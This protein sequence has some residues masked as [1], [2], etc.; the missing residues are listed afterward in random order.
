MPSLLRIVVA[1]YRFIGDTLLSIPFLK[2]LREKNPDAV[3]DLLVGAD[4][5]P[6]MEDCPYINQAIVFEPRE[7][8]FFQ[9]V[10]KIREGRYEAAYLLKRSFSSALMMFLAQVPQRIGF[11]T[12]HRGFLLTRKMPYREFDQHEAQCFLD[13]LD[14][15]SSPSD[16]RLESWIPQ[17][18]AEKALSLL[19]AGS[20]P[21]IVL[22][23][24]STN[25]AKR[26]PLAHFQALAETL[27]S[28]FQARLYLLGSP[29]EA[30]FYDMLTEGLSSKSRQMTHN[31]CGKTTV[32]ESLA[33]LK[34]MDLVVA[35][36]SGMIHMAAA[37]DVPIISIFGPMDPQQWHPL[38]DR[39]TVITHADLAC[40]PCRLKPT[41]NDQYF[42]LTE[43]SP[44]LVLNACK[45][46]LKS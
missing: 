29:S 26:W 3:I 18:V 2:T 22:H 32:Q 38:S 45:P 19:D 44:T 41:C 30:G 23:A 42:C 16:L 15:S 1:R 4:G 14:V 40:R 8:G 46:Y 24:T 11:D 7:L 27:V 37:A 9:A 43:I 34:S 20:G 10:K 5:Y 25:L 33:L 39:S 31:L 36:D 35:N 28:Q 21:R 17:S 13:L 12:D 6:L